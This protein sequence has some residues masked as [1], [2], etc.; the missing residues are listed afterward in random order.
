MPETLGDALPAAIHRVREEVLPA[1][2]GIGAAG[3]PAIQLV[4]N[5]AIRE[6]V[7]ALASGDVTRMARAYQALA[8]IKV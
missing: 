1:Y 2:E 5:P 8:D 4:I 3:Q 6:G 7:D